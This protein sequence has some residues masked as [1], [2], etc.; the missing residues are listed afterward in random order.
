MT[1]LKIHAAERRPRS[2][3]IRHFFWAW[4]TDVLT[5]KNKRS[6]GGV[7]RR[8]ESSPRGLRIDSEA[9]KLES[10]I[11]EFWARKRTITGLTLNDLCAIKAIYWY[12]SLLPASD[13]ARSA[14]HLGTSV[15]CWRSLQVT[16]L[17]MARFSHHERVFVVLGHFWSNPKKR[18][19]ACETLHGPCV[20]DLKIRPTVYE[21]ELMPV[22]CKLFR[23]SEYRARKVRVY[24]GIKNA[25]SRRVQLPYSLR[26]G[27]FC[28]LWFGCG[29]GENDIF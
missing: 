17:R 20:K 1:W 16:I 3:W 7:Q 14:V 13:L 9:S 10:M 21:C 23:G 24:W 5:K 4:S 18:L 6:C 28:L 25:E 26:Q 2:S 27:S 29:I 8:V 11:Q 19:R 15:K 22:L 12:F